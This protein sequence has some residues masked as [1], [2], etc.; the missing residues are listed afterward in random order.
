MQE[1]N[2]VY[3]DNLSVSSS[4]HLV[5]S[6]DTSKTMLYVL[7]AMVPACI[8]SVVFFGARAL[9]L[10]IACMLASVVFELGYEKLMKKENTVRDLSAC[11]TGMILALNMP[12]NFPIW[13]AVI[14]CFVAIVIVKMLYGGIGRNIANPAIVGR[15]VLLLSFTTQM[16]TW[17]LTTFQKAGVDAVTG[18]TPLGLLAD[19]AFNETPSLMQMFIGNIGGA[20]GET[21]TIAILLGCAFLIY[22]KIISPIIPCVFIG[23]VFV[24]ALCYYTFAGGEASALHMALFHVLSGGVCF[25]AVFCATDYVTSPIMKEAKVIYAIG[26]GLV[27]MIIRLFCAYPEGVSFAILFMNVLTPLIDGMVVNRVYGI[28]QREKEAKKK[29]KEEAKKGSE[30]KKEV[31]A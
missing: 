16:T 9:V 20:M 4:P 11:V 17:P 22:K 15:I 14:G 3:Y 29:A 27:T 6:L 23:T 2:T 24:F 7:M 5:T 18:A 12:A 28:T 21:C 25:G 8:A 10:I 31:A 26:C 1:N 30:E 19:G 13:M